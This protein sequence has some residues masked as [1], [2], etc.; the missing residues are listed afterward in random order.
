M[1][2]EHMDKIKVTQQ[3]RVYVVS[4]IQHVPWLQ[5]WLFSELKQLSSKMFITQDYSDLQAL[6]L[7]E[8]PWLK[9]QE[10]ESN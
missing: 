7:T 5:R 1:N 3:G 10:T 9:R 2:K 4:Q 6:G 8:R